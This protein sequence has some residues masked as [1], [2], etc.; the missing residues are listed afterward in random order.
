[1]KSLWNEKEAEAFK[2]DSVQMRV[3]TSR[4][5][6][7]DPDLVLH[8]GGNTSVKVMEKNL[9]G[10][11]EELLYVKGSGWD[12]GV[13]E[14]AGFAPVKLEVLKKMGA[15]DRLTD[16][17]MVRWQKAAM[18]NPGAPGPS[19]EAILHALIPF[20]YVDHTHAD[21]VVTLT[22]TNGGEERIR[23]LY[24]D[25]VLIIP[26]VMPG[27]VLAKKVF[28]LAQGIDWKALDGMI[29]MNHG[30][31]TFADDARESYEKMIQLVAEAENFLKEKGAFDAPK[32]AL[33]AAVLP[34]EKVAEIRQQVSR[35]M[36]KA[37]IAELDT[38]QEA[39]GFA[40][41]P[42]VADIVTRGPLTP[43]HVIRTKRI[44]VIIG[45]DT[46][47][48]IDNY[49]ATYIEYFQRNTSGKLT[50]LDTAPR[51]AVLPK[52]GTLAFGRNVKEAGIIRDISQHTVRSIQRAEALGGWKALPENDIFDVEY[53]ELEQAKLKKGGT[54]PMLNG[55]IALVTGAASGIGKACVERLV[56]H[57]A[58][59]TALDI[60]PAITEMFPQNQ[61]LGMICDV[62]DKNSITE[63]VSATIHRFGGLDI[64]ICNAG[65]FPP[66]KK[67]EAMDDNTWNQSLEINLT[68]NQ[69][70]MTL[71][72]PY[73]TKGIDPAIVIIGSKNV[74][75]PG[76]GAGAYSVAKAGL[77]QLAR[78]VA[79]ELGPYGVRVNT[80]H[81]NAV[82]DTAIWTPE[83]LESRAKHYNLTV[84]EYKKNNILKV[85]ITSADI[86][87]MA[88]AMAGPLFSKTTGAQVPMDGG[89]DRII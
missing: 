66:S 67:V 6:G 43:D 20:R 41:L 28:E 23:E 25:R 71:S 14:S 62:T 70:L 34:L 59:V 60:N 81:P 45:E 63:A 84:E 87:E 82:F 39:A 54:E 65:I 73:L 19:V 36:G 38:S 89:I 75:A 77:T 50:C 26:Y 13:I 21:A 53:W 51:W 79:L 55:K 11:E 57:G 58:A 24:G 18:T 3:Y 76:P 68:A 17:D 31:F 80:V 15:L 61:V 74:P 56:A 12:L 2:G 22:N 78:V 44:P 40:E 10:E 37:M 27:F 88:C 47:K 16:T 46:A 86:G 4:L 48:A 49:S 69:R 7:R 33:N 72:A 30:V 8:G 9:F 35:Q 1:M 83:V 5:L 52:L 42:N 64:L 32:T 29:L 85:E